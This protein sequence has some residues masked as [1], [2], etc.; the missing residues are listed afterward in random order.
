MRG[1]RE[2]P[3]NI[4]RENPCYLPANHVTGNYRC[5]VSHIPGIFVSVFFRS[6]KTSVQSRSLTSCRDSNE[7][8]KKENDEGIFGAKSVFFLL[9]RLLGLI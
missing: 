6:F 2:K 5:Q 4:T 3:R 7:S 1:H 8:R 9:L